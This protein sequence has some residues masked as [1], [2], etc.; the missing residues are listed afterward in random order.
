MCSRVPQTTPSFSDLLGGLPEL[1]EVLMVMV[2][3]CRREGYRP[4]SA[5][6][7]GPWDRG[8]ERAG[9]RLGCRLPAGVR[10]Q[11]S[12]RQK[13]RVPTR[14]ERCEPGKPRQAVVSRVLSG[15]VTQAWLMGVRL[16]FSLQ[17]LQRSGVKGLSNPYR[18]FQS[19]GCWN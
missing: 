9:T 16:T 7:V 4:Q 8:R 11:P 6:R 13:R 19:V 2:M 14:T 1:G 18:T 15:V 12:R 17:P 5:E 3:A 10:R